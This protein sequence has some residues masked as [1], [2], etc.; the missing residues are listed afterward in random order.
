VCVCARSPLQLGLRVR[1]ELK[2][3]GLRFLYDGE[4]RRRKREAPW[5]HIGCAMV[6][7]CVCA[8]LARVHASRRTLT[9]ECA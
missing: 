5:A 2:R 8:C 4:T 3:L 6:H 7:A 1:F 9:I